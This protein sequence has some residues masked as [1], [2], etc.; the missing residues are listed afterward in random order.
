MMYAKEEIENE[1]AK[2]AKNQW[3]SAIFSSIAGHIPGISFSDQRDEFFRLIFKWLEEGRIRFSVPNE[4]WQP[5]DDLWD[6]SPQ[7]IVAYLRAR[8]PTEAADEDDP[9]INDYMYDIPAVVWKQEDGSWY[10]S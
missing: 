3:V 10:G 2:G 9:R 6:A 7:E 1:I 4:L 8:W 5:G